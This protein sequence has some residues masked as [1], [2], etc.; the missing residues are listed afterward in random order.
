[1]GILYPAHRISWRDPDATVAV[2]PSDH[3]IAAEERFMAEVAQLARWVDAH[4]TSVVLLAAE[5]TA[6]EVE[7]GWIEPGDGVGCVGD[8][9]IRAVKSCWE[10]PS[11]A[12]ARACMAAGHLWNTSIVVAKVSALLALGDVAVPALN[13]RLTRLRHFDGTPDEAAAVH[14]AY[15]LMPKIDFSREVLETCPGNLAV[16]SL[17][18]LGWS[19]LGSPSRVMD[20]IADL[21]VL[22]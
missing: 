15:E 13:D 18:G 16:Y 5:P 19:D 21:P 14:Q 7:Y 1:A 3:L 17:R 6:P 9:Q 10:K 11:L 22:P 8:R 2:F 12:T 20:A 4:P